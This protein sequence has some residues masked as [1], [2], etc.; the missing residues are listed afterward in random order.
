V[1]YLVHLLDMYMGLATHLYF[2]YME[3]MWV[4]LIRT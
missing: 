2:V 3:I 1:S 4:F